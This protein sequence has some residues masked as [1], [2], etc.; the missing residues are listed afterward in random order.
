MTKCHGR[1]SKMLPVLQSHKEN[2]AFL[3]W[4]RTHRSDYKM[5]AEA[6]CPT[7]PSGHSLIWSTCSSSKATWFMKKL[8]TSMQELFYVRYSIKEVPYN[9]LRDNGCKRFPRYTSAKFMLRQ[10]NSGFNAQC[11]KP[12]LLKN[13]WTKRQNRTAQNGPGGLSTMNFSK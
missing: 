11:S 5:D 13:R 2:L 12:A 10:S 4:V 3:N 6:S 9:N 1:E 7:I 8:I